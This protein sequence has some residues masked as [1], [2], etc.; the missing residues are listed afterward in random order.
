MKRQ[1][2]K[3]G[4]SNYVGSFLSGLGERRAITKTQVL[5][6]LALRNDI[7]D[8]LTFDQTESEYNSEASFYAALSFSS[9]LK[10]SS[11]RFACIYM[12]TAE[13]PR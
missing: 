1:R 7:S 2:S 3:G 5:L 8:Y 10:R 4:K 6:L 11:F 13:L 12:V 9:R